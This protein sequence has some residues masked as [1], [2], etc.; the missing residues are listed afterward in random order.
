MNDPILSGL[1]DLRQRVKADY[2]QAVCM[3]AH[4]ARLLVTSAT[5]VS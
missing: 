4:A 5:A 1:G 2:A 3:L